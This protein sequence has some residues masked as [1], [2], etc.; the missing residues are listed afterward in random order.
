MTEPVPETVE[1]LRFRVRDGLV[2]HRRV[3]TVREEGRR[4]VRE[5]HI[6]SY[7]RAFGRSEIELSADE[8][9][10]HAH[11]LEPLNEG[12]AKLL[13]SFTYRPPVRPAETSYEATLAG[14]VTTAVVE[15]LRTAG[16]LPAR[17]PKP[18]R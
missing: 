12:A 3:V 7:G 13:D 8:V 15:A 6:E 4:E 5:H 9:K 16:V 10:L 14:V 17:V 11:A 1:P 18:A 2:V